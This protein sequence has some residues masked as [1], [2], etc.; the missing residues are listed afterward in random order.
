MKIS[1]ISILFFYVYI[2]LFMNLNLF[3]NL[4]LSVHCGVITTPLNFRANWL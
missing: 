4:T 2:N 1:K 3:I